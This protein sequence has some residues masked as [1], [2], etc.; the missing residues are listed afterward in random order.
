MAKFSS[1]SY[2]TN[3]IRHTHAVG[4]R[5]Y[6]LKIA[7][8][9]T[10]LRLFHFL[11]SVISDITRTF[12]GSDSIITFERGNF[13]SRTIDHVSHGRKHSLSNQIAFEKINKLS[14]PQRSWSN[15]NS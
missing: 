6:G 11:G 8:W 14:I 3:H 5:F 1:L 13:S 9:I 4:S 2:Y 10:N 7:V 15:C 12:T